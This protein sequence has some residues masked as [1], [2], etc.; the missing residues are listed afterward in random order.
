MLKK[1]F[2]EVELYNSFH[3]FLFRA[4]LSETYYVTYCFISLR[5]KRWETG[6]EG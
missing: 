3:S 4:V 2:L 1:L 5:D 6:G